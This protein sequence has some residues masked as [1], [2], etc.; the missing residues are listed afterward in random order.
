MFTEV[1]DLLVDQLGVDSRVVDDVGADIIDAIG[2]AVRLRAVTDHVL[3][4]LS[5]QAERV[6]IAKRSG[7]RTRELLMANGMAPV[8][9]DRC[10]R[11]G[12]ALSEL[13]TLHRH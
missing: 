13:P 6:G 12:R 9:A 5:A 10:L 1:G 11:V 2:G 4:V 7:M 3:A 8:V